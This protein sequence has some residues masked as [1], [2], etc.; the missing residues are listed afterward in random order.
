VFALP[1]ILHLKPEEVDTLEKRGAYTVGIVGCG[2]RGALYAKAFAGAG[3]KVFCADADQSLV[4]QLSKANLV[5]VDR[6]AKTKWRSYLR[7]GQLTTTSELGKA[8]SQSHIIIVTTNV[9]IDEKKTPDYQ[10]IETLC[11][12]IGSSLQ[13]ESLVIYAGVAGLGFTQGIF[14]ETLEN[15]SGLKT[16]EDFA[17]AYNPLFGIIS[18]N[19]NVAELELLVAA[20]DK[21][22]LNTAALVFQTITKKV[23]EKL[24][25]VKTAELAALFAAVRR[26]ANVALAN[27][28]AVFCEN[29]G[30]DYAATSKLIGRGI[31]DVALATVAEEN[32]RNEAYLLL[33][34]AETLNVKLRL[35]TL[36]RN[37]NE[38]QVKHAVNLT[39]EA[40]RNG[41]KP[42]RR[43]RVALLGDTSAGTGAGAFV[44]MLQ[45]KGAKITWY[46]PEAS[47]KETSDT[48]R[49]VKRT[50]NETVEGADCLVIL[51]D[52]RHFGSLNLKK[53]RALM[54]SPAAL[55]D[56]AGAVEPGK[57]EEAGFVYRG[58]G[59][60]VWKK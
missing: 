26:D 43:A 48:S 3:Y 56:L 47:D 17:L 24:A 1:P 51:A 35:P 9:K 40:L 18:E 38:E 42:L 52:P 28:L 36:A 20:S 11:K 55:V 4:R 6:E 45:E 16:G 8:I 25:D 12:Q 58:L 34:N 54:K 15:T 32:N 29:A 31:C 33:E 7:T 22:S 23:V 59:R 21:T 46:D 57:V 14:K 53:M 41:G 27:E 39:Q 50:L 44:E 13:R 60:G 5:F 30:M 2:L 49:L 37:I 10:E 19:T